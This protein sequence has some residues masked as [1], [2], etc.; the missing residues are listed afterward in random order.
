MV[1]TQD[2]KVR[3]LGTQFNVVSQV[4]KQLAKVYLKE[5]KVELL[6][7]DDQHQLYL[8]PGNEYIYDRKAKSY[9]LN[10]KASKDCLAWVEGVLLLDNIS[11]KE[12]ILQLESFYNVDIIINDKE[13][14]ALPVYA[15]LQNESLEEFLELV[16]LILPLN[17]KLEKSSLKSDGT[18]TKRKVWLM[19]R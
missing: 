4:D 13:L 3:V 7:K 5:G 6:D 17:Y 14:E 11:L 10:E 9:A 15:R 2:F 8:K 1:S 16:Q 18:I 12:A 19:H